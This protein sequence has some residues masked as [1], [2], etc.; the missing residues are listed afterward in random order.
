MERVTCGAFPAPRQ[1][2]H[3]LR[4]GPTTLLALPLHRMGG[5]ACLRPNTR[6]ARLVDGGSALLD[7]R[8]QGFRERRLPITL[9]A[10]QR[11]WTVFLSDNPSPSP[12]PKA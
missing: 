5:A 3:A 4:Q 8:D 10:A 6:G 7:V 9:P 1:V 12:K 2:L 11:R